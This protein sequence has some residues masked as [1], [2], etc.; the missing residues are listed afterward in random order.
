MSNSEQNK[1]KKNKGLLVSLAILLIGSIAL[2]FLLYVKLTNYKTKAQ[3]EITM[4]SQEQQEVNKL[5]EDSKELTKK[6]EGD[7]AEMDEDIQSKLAEIKRIKIENDS[8]INSG[9][10][11]E[12]LNRRLKAN[13][14]MVR[15]LNEQLE[16][17]VDELLLEN[18]KL[19]SQ[20][21]ELTGDLDS[22]STMNNELS[23]KVAIA[24]ALQI[25]NPN[26]SSWRKRNS[27]SKPW[28]KTSL[29][30]RTNKIEVDITIMA[31]AI[32]K[33]GEKKVTMIVTAPDGE[34]LGKLDKNG[35]NVDVQ[36]NGTKKYAAFKAFTYSGN[37][38]EI[39]LEYITN[40]TK[41]PIGSYQIDIFIDDEIVNTSN[42]S[43]K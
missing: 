13:L 14:A 26:I 39:T 12:E 35:S 17:K 41:L 36:A 42:Y 21:T 9:M 6:L 2:N 19:E 38:Q 3:Q 18:R 31:N 7:V 37:A 32:T 33:T 4:L 30:R 28:K 43:L 40:Q 34:L 11:K 27:Q 20:N 29:A 1:S 16:T 24:S 10:K 5:F 23:Q 8:L 15:K 25:P 22:V